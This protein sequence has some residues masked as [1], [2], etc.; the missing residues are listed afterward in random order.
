LKIKN[1]K[2]AAPEESL[3]IVKLIGLLDESTK[4]SRHNTELA[5]KAIIVKP[6]NEI[7][8]KFIK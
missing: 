1:D 4:T 3:I 5:A 8:F 2:M 6:V 7:S